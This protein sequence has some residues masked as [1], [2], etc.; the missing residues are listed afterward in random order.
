MNSAPWTGPAISTPSS[1]VRAIH[2]KYMPARRAAQ[3]KASATASRRKTR[4]TADEN[5]TGGSGFCRWSGWLEHAARTKAPLKR[6]RPLLKN[7]APT[8]TPRGR[9]SCGGRRGGSGGLASALGAGL[10]GVHALGDRKSAA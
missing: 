7:G 5:F 8:K 3:L 10:V 4:T 9:R 1:G 2:L 6:K